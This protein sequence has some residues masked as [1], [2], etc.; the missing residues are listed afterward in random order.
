VTT[1]GRTT[2]VKATDL[3]W[4]EAA[5]NYVKL[6]VGKSKLLLREALATL[7]TQ[8]DP[9]TFVACPSERDGQ[10]RFHRG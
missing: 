6:H 7:E 1:E 8:L 3:E 2:I 4:I 10:S 9:R 5:A